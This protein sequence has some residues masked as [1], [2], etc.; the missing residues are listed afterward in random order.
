MARPVVDMTGFR[1]GSLVAIELVGSPAEAGGQ[2][3]LWKCRCDCGQSSIVRQG[4]LKSGRTARCKT[5]GACAGAAARRAPEGHVGLSGVVAYYQRNARTRKLTWELTRNQVAILTSQSCHY[6]GMPPQMIAF[7]TSKNRLTRAIASY[8]H[9]GID[10]IN[11][12]IGYTFENCVSCCTRCNRAKREDPHDD[13][14][15]WLDQVADFRRA[16]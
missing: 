4:H 12:S 11:N 1:S 8:V 16:R 2:S 14:I 13:F 15:V 7:G 10:R 9:G 5:C 3:R 6:C